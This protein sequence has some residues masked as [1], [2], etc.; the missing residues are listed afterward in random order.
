MR[1]P[2]QR[3]E[4]QLAEASKLIADGTKAIIDLQAEGESQ[5]NAC[6]AKS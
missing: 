1:A 4:E 6:L 5:Q 3:L 2:M